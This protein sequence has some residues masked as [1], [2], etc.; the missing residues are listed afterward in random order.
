L[1]LIFPQ[2]PGCPF[3]GAPVPGR[4]LCPG[5]SGMVAAYRQEPFCAR[6]GRFAA[7]GAV[8]SSA[9]QSRLCFD[10]RKHDWPYILVRAGGP[11]EGI[12]KDTIHR[13]K[14]AGRR[15]LSAQLGQLMLAAAEREP[16]YATAGLIV[17]VPLSR[18]KLR[19]RGYNQAGLLAR[20]L[21]R[22]LNL[23]VAGGC[24]VKVIDTPPQANL[25]RA[26]RIENLHGAFK[27]AKPEVIAGQVV[28]VIDDVL[29][30][31]STMAEAASTLREAGAR[32]VLGLTAAAG[33][34]I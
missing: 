14:Y 5:C 7:H 1:D 4:G 18:E 16:L 11:Y 22:A 19:R 6:C 33:R 27:V 34:Y 24:L 13:F 21:G 31:G 29:T 17:P 12:L 20:E 32:Q 26:A 8:L 28:L 25:D 9:G 3:C 10:C 2:P 15:G 23:P 30:T